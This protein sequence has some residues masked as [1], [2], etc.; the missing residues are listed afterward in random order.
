MEI[1][2]DSPGR[3]AKDRINRLLDQG[4]GIVTTAGVLE[5]GISKTVFM[6][7]AASLELIKL[8]HGIYGRREAAEKVIPENPLGYL[9]FLQLRYPKLIFSHESALFLH[10]MLG[11]LS[12]EIPVSMGRGYHARS[13]ESHG[14]KVYRLGTEKL[15]LGLT[16]REGAFGRSLRFYDLERTICDLIRSRSRIDAGNLARAIRFYA[17]S[18]DKKYTKLMEYAKEFRVRKLLVSYMELLL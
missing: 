5:E 11:D 7:H 17:A 13:M 16:V 8:A 12:R 15:T 18:P 9:S 14:L 1:K 10:G 4:R 6:R 3:S 2:M